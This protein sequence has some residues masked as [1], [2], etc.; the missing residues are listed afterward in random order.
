MD[1]CTTDKLGAYLLII[2][3]LVRRVSLSTD[4]HTKNARKIKNNNISKKYIIDWLISSAN[5]FILGSRTER[6][7]RDCLY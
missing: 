3:Y 7:G 2:F 6:G 5:G 4:D 1:V